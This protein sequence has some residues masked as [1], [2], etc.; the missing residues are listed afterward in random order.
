MGH[1]AVYDGL[2]EKK[3][4]FASCSKGGNFGI[5]G[6]WVDFLKKQLFAA[7]LKQFQ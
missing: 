2:V 5:M 4:V 1:I 3:Q 7:S 6:E